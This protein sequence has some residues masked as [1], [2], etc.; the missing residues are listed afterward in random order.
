VKRM[1]VLMMAGLL[2]SLMAAGASADTGTLRMERREWRQHERIQQGWRSGE[3]RRGERA[4]LRAGE[5]RID[6]IEW[7]AGRDGHFSRLE[8]GRIERA[9]DRESRRIYRL[10]HNRRTR[11]I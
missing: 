8:R 1:N 7:R 5:R 4:R 9:Q 11:E 3:L 10:K 2:L 6:R